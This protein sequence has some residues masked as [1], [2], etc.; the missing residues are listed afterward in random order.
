[1]V[2]LACPSRWTGR[3]TILPRR[4]ERHIS[5]IRITLF[6]QIIQ[7]QLVKLTNRRSK[8]VKL[9]WD[10]K[11]ERTQMVISVLIFVWMA[12]HLVLLKK[13][14]T[15]KRRTK[16]QELPISVWIFAGMANHWA[17]LRSKE[18][19][20]LMIITLLVSPIIQI[21]LVSLTKKKS[22]EV[23][24]FW[25]NRLKMTQMVILVLISIWEVSL[26]VLLRREELQLLMTKIMLYSL[27]TQIQLVKLT[28]RRSKEVKLY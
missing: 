1:M 8:E 13:N 19:L 2:I 26:S 14:K 6:L 18:S 10:N 28:N 3:L 27:I 4:R 15:I 9:Y 17:L 23:K 12:N 22:G 20:I 16:I 25:D 5:M 7:I 24:P 21:P 11:L